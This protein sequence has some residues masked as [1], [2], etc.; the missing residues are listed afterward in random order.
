[1]STWKTTELDP[2]NPLRGG[3]AEDGLQRGDE[4]PKRP[5]ADAPWPYLRQELRGAP[6]W[7]P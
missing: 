3:A 6:G 7:R 1:M 5:M 2:G 4:R